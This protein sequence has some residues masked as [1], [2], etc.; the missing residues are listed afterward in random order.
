[1]RSVR[2]CSLGSMASST[3]RHVDQ[4]E[5]KFVKGRDD[6]AGDDE[7]DLRLQ[8]PCGH[9]TA[10]SSL[11]L[12][13]YTCLERGETNFY[14]PALIE[15]GACCRKELKVALIRSAAMHTVEGLKRLCDFEEKL[16]TIVAK[17]CCQSKECPGCR[18]L[19][20]RRDKSNMRVFCTN[21]R[22]KKGTNYEFCWQCLRPWKG[23]SS[24]SVGCGNKECK[25]HNL[26]VLQKC[27]VIDLPYSGIKGCPS[28][29]ACPTCGLLIEHKNMCKFVMCCRC[30]VNFCF[31]CL[32][33]AK[34]CQRRRANTGHNLTCDMPVAP[35]QTA[36]S[37]WSGETRCSRLSS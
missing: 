32:N 36:I 13:C 1:M 7:I 23:D 8:L 20:E 5:L 2:L 25:D 21:C 22:A 12:W 24:S 34:A 29:R 26:V 28:I 17:Q 37:V 33:T 14:C 27:K 6:I 19:I 10:P 31:A 16:A 3:L 4:A 11:F 15:E 18:S 9:T 35:K 30:G